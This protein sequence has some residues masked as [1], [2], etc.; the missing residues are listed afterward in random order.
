[1]RMRGMA[2]VAALAVLLPAS[3][4]T[5]APD[6]APGWWAQKVARQALAAGD[7]WAATGAGTTGGAAADA[8]HVFVVHDRDELAAALAGAEPKIV[9]VA[10]T[11]DGLAGPDGP[12]TCADLADPGYTL[13]S[14]LAAYDPAVWGRA[15]DPSGPIEQARVRSVA[16]QRA[17]TE[18]RVGPNTTVLGLSGATLRHLTLMI[19]TAPNVIVR[20]LAF[21]DAADCFPRWRPTDG[22]EGN[23][24][25]EY[26]LVSVRRSTNV[27]VDHNT[28]SDGDN[29][30]STQPVY[31]GRPWQVHDG[32]LDITHTSDLVTVSANV[33]THHDKTM[34]IGSSDTVGPDV[35]KLRVTLRHNVFDGVGQR[36][37]RVR[38]GQVDVYNNTFRVREPYDYSVGLG[39][40]SAVYLENNFFDLGDGIPADRVLKDWK[41]TAVTELGSWVRTGT[42]LGGPVS[43]LA[44]YNGAH[45]PDFGPDAGW[46]PELRAYK[47]APAAV[48]PLLTLLSG[49]GR[50]LP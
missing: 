18:L 46:T 8:T 7:G 37:P 19:D 48:V 9:Y 38:F 12:L 44:A 2:A 21:E 42:G 43:L 39:I 15:T 3:A 10:G 13:E 30:D 40:Q 22:A 33:F 24:N 6:S 20:N 1:M 26:D 32:A 35:G 11:I 5:A 45:D 41:G 16:T 27:W 4:A 36:A 25:S 34:L 31:F 28:F 29:P 49:A 50:L 47:P 14:Y 23:W 17:R